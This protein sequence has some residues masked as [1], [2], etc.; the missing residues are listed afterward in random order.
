MNSA[1]FRNLTKKTLF[2][3]S[4]ATA[5]RVSELQALSSQGE[6]LIISYL[7]EFLAKTERAFNHLPREFQLKS[8]TPLVGRD[9]QERLLCPV[10]ALTYMLERSKNFSHKPRNLFI[11]PS[12]TAKP[13]LRMP[14]HF[15]SK[16]S[17][18]RLMSSFQRNF[19]NH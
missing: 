10:Q 7:P 4:L 8:L 13:L 5:K 9:D 2:L 17:S 14:C 1:S 11:S 15:F 19:S 3:F 18:S 16:K 6:D 12:N